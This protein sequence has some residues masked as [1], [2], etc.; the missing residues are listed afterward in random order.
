MPGSASTDKITIAAPTLPLERRTRPMTGT[1]AAS[2]SNM[3]QSVL[4][5]EQTEP[6]LSPQIKKK[7]IVALTARAQASAA[8]YTHA[9]GAEA[10]AD[11][12]SL[13]LEFMPM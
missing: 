8:R 10:G 11:S 2:A 3:S 1:P 9:A 7:K 4:L 13:V 12:D 5:N 6:S